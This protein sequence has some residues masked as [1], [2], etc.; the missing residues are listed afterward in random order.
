[1]AGERCA[2]TVVDPVRSAPSGSTIGQR[3][4]STSIV[5]VARTPS[6][7]VPSGSWESFSDPSRGSSRVVLGVVAPADSS[8][9]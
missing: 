7:L 9:R 5:S 3:P 6:A 4:H 1:M 2:V 8:R